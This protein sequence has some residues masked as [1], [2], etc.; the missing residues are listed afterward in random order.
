MLVGGL[1]NSRIEQ[2]RLMVLPG[3][4]KTEDFPWIT[5]AAAEKSNKFKLSYNI[6]LVT[7]HAILLLI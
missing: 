2:V 4:T 3:F 1:E 7:F 5:A 6:L